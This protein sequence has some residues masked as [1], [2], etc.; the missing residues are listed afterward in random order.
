MGHHFVPQKYLR[1]F[2]SSLKP[3]AL[4]QFDKRTLSFSNKPAA[5]KKIA[6]QPKFY[7]EQTEQNLNRFVEI[8]GNQVIDKLRSGNLS[9]TDDE[10]IHLSVYI[11][12]ML[13]RIPKSRVK[14]KAIAPEVLKD[15]ASEI[16]ELI[17]YYAEV[18]EISL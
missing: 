17:Q 3:N 13:K 11:A 14:G 4:W 7:D 1:G 18:G 5:I 15:V 6:Q 12:T 2:T 8:P 9:L 10:R 16:R